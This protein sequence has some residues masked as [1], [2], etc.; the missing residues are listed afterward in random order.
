VGNA[1]NF[2]KFLLLTR[3]SDPNEWLEKFIA[4][5]VVV[6]IS[7]LHYRLVNIGIQANFW[8]AIGK[9]LFLSLLV[10]AG[11]IATCRDGAHGKLEGLHDYGTTHKSGRVQGSPS[12]VNI[13]VAIL[14]VFF[15]YQ[16]WEN[17]SECL[18]W[19]SLEKNKLT[20]VQITLH[21]RLKETQPKEE[22]G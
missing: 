8:L 17:A 16:G 9:V 5:G 2:A 7:L 21:L 4:C 6:A 13:V 1:L 3:D 15:S 20:A 19:T 22:E 11:F 14:L 10:F 18:S 12:A